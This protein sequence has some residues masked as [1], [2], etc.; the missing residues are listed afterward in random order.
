MFNSGKELTT[1]SFNH[2]AGPNIKP[3]GKPGS[4]PLNTSPGW[5]ASP[6]DNAGSTG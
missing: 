5:T 1:P 2:T 3:L 4:S 6:P